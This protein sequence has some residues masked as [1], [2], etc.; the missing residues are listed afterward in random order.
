MPRP[1]PSRS[2]KTAESS[3]RNA[4]VARRRKAA[5]DGGGQDSASVY[6]TVRGGPAPAMRTVARV[7]AAT[8]SAAS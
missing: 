1:E 7:G 2:S 8:G 3:D 4:P 6:E 5:P